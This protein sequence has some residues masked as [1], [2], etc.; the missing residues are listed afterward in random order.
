MKKF[1]AGEKNEFRAG[2]PL[3]SDGVAEAYAPRRTVLD[4][5]V[6][7]RTTSS[8]R[9]SA[10]ASPFVVQAGAVIPAALVTG[11]RS[12]LPGQVIGHLERQL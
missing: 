6:D 2:T 5:P 1:R 11:M 12:D 7:R 10:P 4:G 8:D 9:L 3:P